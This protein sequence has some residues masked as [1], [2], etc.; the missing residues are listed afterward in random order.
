M[1]DS[2]PGTSSTP[3]PA[4]N[5]DEPST[6]F[7]LSDSN[8]NSSVS[9]DVPVG[10]NFFNES[11]VETL[12]SAFTTDQMEKFQKRVGNGYDVFVENDSVAWLRLY[13]PH[14]LPSDISY[15]DEHH[16]SSSVSGSESVSDDN[17][18]P[19]PS[20]LV[21]PVS[22]NLIIT[23]TVSQSLASARMA[24]SNVTEFLTIPSST[25]VKAGKPPGRARVLTSEESLAMMLEKEQK[26]KE[27]EEAKERRKLECVEKNYSEKLR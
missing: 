21:T 16:P 11:S 20:A 18:L 6:S 17:E 14:Y 9:G 19:L 15:A 26:K 12:S 27:E 25:S 23:P 5:K 1:D 8:W 22:E 10:A 13:H 3:P 2:Y 7:G 24:L 4:G